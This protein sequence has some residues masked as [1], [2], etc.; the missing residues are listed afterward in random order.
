V[1]L[2]LTN[3]SQLVRRDV[4]HFLALDAGGYLLAGLLRFSFCSMANPR[5]EDII[6]WMFRTVLA[7]R[8]FGLP[9]AT[10]RV[11]QENIY[12]ALPLYYT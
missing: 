12:V 4:F 5:A 7:L 1:L 10:M 9:L 8:P 11:T 3:A 2:T 6:W